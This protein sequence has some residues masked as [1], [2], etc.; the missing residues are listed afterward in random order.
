MLAEL[1]IQ[2]QDSRKMDALPF[3][4]PTE[5]LGVLNDFI[6]DW[7]DTKLLKCSIVQQKISNHKLYKSNS[8]STKQDRHTVG[9]AAFTTYE[10]IQVS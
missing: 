8:L 5:H 4:S 3:V 6:T 2:R 10:S 1:D 9:T 7:Q